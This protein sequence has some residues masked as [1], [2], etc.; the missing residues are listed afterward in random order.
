L[1][2]FALFGHFSVIFSVNRASDERVRGGP[3]FLVKG[4][5]SPL[6][7]DLLRIYVENEATKRCLILFFTG[8]ATAG[9]VLWNY[10]TKS[11]SEGD[12]YPIWGTCL[13][14]ELIA[15]L[16]NNGGEP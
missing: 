10:A 16:S 15:T 13:G 5:V 11:N 2:I 6:N 7:S 3:H 9:K 4:G 14:F 8:Y 1:A 12:Q